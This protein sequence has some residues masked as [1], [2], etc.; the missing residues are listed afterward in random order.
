MID[1]ATWASIMEFRRRRDWQQFHTFKNLAAALVVEAGE[2]L[3]TVQWTADAGL[4]ARLA[5]KRDDIELELADV[6]ILLAYLVTD[7]GVDLDAAVRR[8]LAINEQRYPVERA[9]GSSRK[10]SEL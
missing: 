9:R 8:K 6:A 7:L 10:Y 2:L 3:E 5:E 1:S 4:P